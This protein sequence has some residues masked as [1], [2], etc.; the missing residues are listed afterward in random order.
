MDPLIITATPNISWLNPNIKFPKTPD[1]IAEASKKSADAG[2]SILHIHAEK[3]WN[4]AIRETRKK[5]NA[6]IQCGMSSLSINERMDV[7]KERADMISII[8][9]H[10]DEAF[11]NIETHK[12]HDRQELIDYSKL[13]KKYNVRP[14]FEVWHAGH[15]WNLNFLING[16]YID[17]PY[18]TTLFF[19]WPGGNW[20]PPT[21]DEYLYRRKLMP[22]KSVINVSVM[23]RE[24]EKIITAAILMGDHVRVGTE[25]YPYIG[26]KEATTEEL[27]SWVSDI[28]KA[29]GRKVATPDEA[30][31][32]IGINR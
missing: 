26:K 9:G 12:L 32:I 31:R 2:A 6:I 23:G 29:L 5:T 13:L 11:V 16:N 1:E 27:V 3:I 18:F 8:L 25:D 30:R 4:Y 17:P 21:I 22:K 24:Q 19:G 15:I 10:H 14:E 20:T 7:F 28:S